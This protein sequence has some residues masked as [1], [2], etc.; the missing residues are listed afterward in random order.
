MTGRTSLKVYS[1]IRKVAKT[2]IVV[3][4]HGKAPPVYIINSMKLELRTY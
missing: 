2:G 4:V 3:D 1:Q